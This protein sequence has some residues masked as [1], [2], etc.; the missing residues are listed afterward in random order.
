MYMI[1]GVPNVMVTSKS[2][3]IRTAICV[4]ISLVTNLRQ[5]SLFD[6]V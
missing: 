3:L 5:S 6:I 2:D 1:N 4:H